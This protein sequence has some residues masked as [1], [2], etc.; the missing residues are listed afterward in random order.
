LI[1]LNR[2]SFIITVFISLGAFGQVDNWQAKWIGIPTAKQDTNLWTCFRKEFSIGSEPRNARVKIAT[3]SKYW[4]WLNGKLIVFEGELKRGPNPRDTY[5]DE[6]DLSKHLHKGKNTIAVLTWYWGRD[7]YDHKS[8]GKAGLLFEATIGD[9]KIGSDKTWKTVVHPSFGSTGPP[10]PNYRLPEYNVYFDARKNIQ[11]WYHPQF[12][13]HDWTNAVEFGTPP[14]APWNNLVKRP[15]PFWKDSGMVDFLNNNELLKET[16]GNAIV[17]KLPKNITITPYFKIEAPAGLKIDIRTDNYKG[18][19][20]YNVRTE[21]VTRAGVQEFE[22]FGYMNGHEVIYSIPAGVKIISLKYRET[23]YNTEMMGRFS[24]D[25]PFFDKLWK[26]SYNTLNVNLRDAI[27]DP[28][29]ER[30]QWWGDAVILMGEIFYAC[31]KNGV[32]AIQKAMRNLVDWQ[33]PDGVLYSP[34]PAGSWDKELPAQM[35]ASI[36]EKGF[37]NYYRYTADTGMMRYVYPAVKRYLDL[38]QLGN[39]GL[40]LHRPG[41]WDWLDW[42]KDID[43]PIIDNAWYFMALKAAVQMAAITGNL[44]DIA[45]YQERMKSIKENF[46]KNFWNG[47]AYKGPGNTGVID[48]RGNGLAVVAGLAGKDKYENLKKVFQT[49]FHASPYMEKYILEAHFIMGDATGGLERMRKRYSN[50]VSSQLST[51]WE[52]WGIGSEGY[53]GGSYN[54]GWAGGPLTLLS[55]YVAGIAPNLPAYK[56]FT[57]MPQPGNLHAIHC[58]ALSAKGNISMDLESNDKKVELKIQIPSNTMAKVGVPKMGL[59]L[60]K[61]SVNEKLMLENKKPFSNNR[62]VHYI[63]EDANYF[64]FEVQ[65]GKWSFVLH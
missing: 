64:I 10:L 35:L 25:D 24:C 6:L 15:I 8:S 31:D 61:V 46:D 40:V 59:H 1:P 36:G 5:Y 37:L 28:D 27:Q 20:E 34:V 32:F 56:T 41:G 7:G 50:M 49:E 21:Y 19:S 26:K 44:S 16:K 45:S 23:R 29:R 2:F 38:W 4:F 11:G 60:S 39:D 42:G 53:G 18:G 30:A 54:H 43:P 58:V 62:A 33:K 57:I 22:T 63:S 48:D 14:M 65:P 3:D 13:D 55:Q 47:T 12:D 51:L 17:A 52:G 9:K